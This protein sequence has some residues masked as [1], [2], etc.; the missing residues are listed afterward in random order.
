MTEANPLPNEQRAEIV[1]IYQQGEEAVIELVSSLWLVIAQQEQAIKD[2]KARVK[3]L[4]NQGNK[5]SKNS[6]KPP[7]SD[8][9]KKRTQSLR[10]KSNRTSGGQPG[11]PGSTL[12]WSEQ[13]DELVTHPVCECHQCGQQL[14]DVAVI[15]WDVSQVHEI[16]PMG[17]QIIEH[18]AEVKTCPQCGEVNR[19]ELPT[20]ANSRIQYG[21]RLKGLMVYLMDG[22]LLPSARVCEVLATVCNIKV[23]EGTLYNAREECYEQLA[24]VEIH[25]REQMQQAQVGHF[26]ETGFRVKG[27]LW[28]LH[29]ASTE[30]LTYY[31]VHT[32]RGRAAIDEM[33]VLTQFTGTSVHD[34]WSSYADYECGHALC[35]AHHL[36]SLRFILECFDPP[37]AAEMMTL[38]IAIK[39]KVEQA[40]E[41]GQTV[42][43]PS[44]S[45]DFEQQY[46]RLIVTGLEANPPPPP[47]VDVKPRGRPKQSPAKNL[48]DRLQKHSSSVL[49][50][51]YDFR[52]PFDNNQAERD[53]RMMKLKQKISGGF[54][55]ESGAKSFCR[56]R[57]YI[58]TLKKQG[59]DV[60]DGIRLAL[61]GFPLFPLLQPE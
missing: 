61:H 39:T 16:P 41:Q 31:F 9:F 2:L 3:E 43:E 29:V 12:E 19:A 21:E 13:V 37:W 22:Q 53:L 27:K 18:Q 24:P 25:L 17:V 20:G 30:A 11:H 45:A 28:W 60:L 38:L 59:L 58:S 40:I 26:D 1:K 32:K 48:L 14:L 6:S 55:S 36:R 35:N 49:A 47:P 8:G 10:T 42:L 33:N 54:R 23:S 34:G 56:I 50:F 46:Q 51:M 57:S 5:D 4:E 7:S 44:Q 15:E 52:V